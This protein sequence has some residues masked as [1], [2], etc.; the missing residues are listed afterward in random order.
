MCSFM[1]LHLA[2]G[3]VGA[4][5]LFTTRRGLTRA[6]ESLVPVEYQVSPLSL[7]APSDLT[8]IGLTPPKTFQDEAFSDLKTLRPLDLRP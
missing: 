4:S 8:A 7:P 3:Q 1:L 5:E 2:C 6:Y